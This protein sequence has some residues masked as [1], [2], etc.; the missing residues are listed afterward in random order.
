M[1]GSSIPA[2]TLSTTGDGSLFVL[3]DEGVFFSA[4]RQELY[5][6]NTAATLVWCCIEDGMSE[7]DVVTARAD[8]ARLLDQWWGAGYIERPRV[9]LPDTPLP[10]ATALARLLVNPRLRAEFAADPQ[11]T[12]AGRC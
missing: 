12:A 5:V 9:L 1:T 2:A 3:G 8:I 4:L 11:A 6:F 7:V 10:F